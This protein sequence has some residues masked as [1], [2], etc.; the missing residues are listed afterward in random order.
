MKRI[1]LIPLALLLTLAATS[2]HADTKLQV[3]W[4]D[5]DYVYN[6]DPFKSI[7]VIGVPERPD[8]RRQLEDSLVKALE[9]NGVHATASLDIMQA[10]TEVNRDSVV[11]ALE[12]KNVD[13]VFLTNLYRTDDTEFVE[14]GEVPTTQRS[15]RDFKLLLWQDY[16]GAYDQSL[17]APTTKKHRLVLENQLYNLESEKLIWS[18]QSY[19]MNPKSADKVIKSLSKEVSEQ[20]RRDGLI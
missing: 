20:L 16:Q 6:N 12:G 5:R 14:G 8:K 17:S 11:A 7:L 1:L 2:L 18:V 4:M 15:D 9:K 13:A 19:S 3:P 10:E